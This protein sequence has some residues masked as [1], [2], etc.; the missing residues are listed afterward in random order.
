MKHVSLAALIALLACGDD[1]VVYEFELPPGFP[2]PRVPVDNPMSEVR[3]ELGRHLFYDT[4]L[5]GN[6]TQACASCHQQERA[7]ADSRARGLGST[8]QEHPRGAMSLANVAYAA[9]LNWANP[10]TR[11]LEAQALV[12]MFGESPVELGL[13]GR[14]EEM[15]AR[16]RAEPVYQDLF[17][18]AFSESDPFTVS[19]VAKAIASFQRTLLS[20]ASAYD[21]FVNG[22]PNAISESAKRGADLFFGEEAECFHCHGGFTFSSSVD[23]AGNVFDQASFQN[24][25]LYNIDGRGAYPPMNTGLEEFTDEDDDMGAFKPPTLRNIAVTAPYMHDGSVATLEEV[26]QNYARGG[27][28]VEEGPFVGDGADNPHKSLFVN[29]FTTT[30]ERLADLQA[31]L[32]SLTD[33]AFLVDPRFSDPWS[34]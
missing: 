4:R 30:P 22:D 2:E 26:L 5:S 20:G 10:V 34:E 11:Q 25:G 23:H 16:L 28:L 1:A 6:E 19:N 13:A 27:R 24:N 12:P 31:F 15:L 17:P 21:R 32:E 9:T 18:A 8:G 7:F 14:E 29:G 33:E 3:V